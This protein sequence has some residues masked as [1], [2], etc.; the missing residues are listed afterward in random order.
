MELHRE[1]PKPA[2]MRPVDTAITCTCG[3]RSTSRMEAL[4]HQA[5][6]LRAEVMHLVDELL[7]RYPDD[8]G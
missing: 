7:A 4:Q 2:G 8:Q 6:S 3:E 5:E 1:V